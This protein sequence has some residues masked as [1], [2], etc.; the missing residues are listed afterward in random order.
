MCSLG[1]L[2]SSIRSVL[3][4][5]GEGGERF[6]RGCITDRWGC[7]RKSEAERR[8]IHRKEEN[9]VTGPLQIIARGFFSFSSFFPPP[10]LLFLFVLE[11]WKNEKGSRERE[12]GEMKEDNSLEFH[13]DQ[14]FSI[15]RI[16]HFF[17]PPSIGRSL[18][19][20]LLF[21]LF[22]SIAVGCFFFFFEQ[23]SLQD[24]G[25]MLVGCFSKYWS[26]RGRQRGGCV[27][28]KSV[29]ILLP[30]FID[31]R[32]LERISSLWALPPPPSLSFSRLIGR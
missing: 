1:L 27:G 16:I 19:S 3:N 10:P 22:L 30:C 31:T 23:C 18:F 32:Q 17:S 4:R 9:R 7:R 13:R 29:K 8:T 12:R 2:A 21:P 14:H 25:G 6:C 15:R 26:I 24:T 11:E 5:E 28:T 20:L